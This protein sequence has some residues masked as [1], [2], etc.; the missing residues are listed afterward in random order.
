MAFYTCPLYDIVSRYK[1]IFICLFLFVC[2][3]L[4]IRLSFCLFLAL[5][6]FIAVDFLHKLLNTDYDNQLDTDASLYCLWSSLDQW[7]KI[8]NSI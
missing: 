6:V 5:T 1:A 4:F 2:F 7:E 3:F 8:I